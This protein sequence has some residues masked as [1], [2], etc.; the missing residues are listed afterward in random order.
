MAPFLEPQ[1]KSFPA[2][3]YLNRLETG[4]APP[5]RYRSSTRYPYSQPSAA[6]DLASGMLS[7][8]REDHHW[9]P[10]GVRRISAAL[11]QQIRSA[12]KPTEDPLHVVQ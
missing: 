8:Y 2:D 6:A 9:S 5:Q 12:H 1:K 11:A 7:F 10:L 3:P 4:A